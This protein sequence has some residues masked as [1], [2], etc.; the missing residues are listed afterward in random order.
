[1]SDSGRITARAARTALGFLAFLLLWGCSSHQPSRPA[2]RGDARPAAAEPPLFSAAETTELGSKKDGK[3]TGEACVKS[4]APSCPAVDR[5]KCASA[6]AKGCVHDACTSAKNQA[7]A[8]LRALVPQEC[9]K[10]IQAN[11]PCEKH[12]C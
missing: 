6:T 9:H 1:M 3:Q 10:Y 8:N 7:K 5:G 2:G 4:D 11:A 12:D